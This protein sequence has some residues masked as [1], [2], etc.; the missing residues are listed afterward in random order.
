MKA[1]VKGL[2]TIGYHSYKD[3]N[4]GML[5]KLLSLF[6]LVHINGQELYRTETVT[7]F[8]DLCLFAPAGLIDDRITWEE[9]DEVSAKA[10]FT[11]NGAEISAVLYFNQ[12]GQLVNF[13]SEDRISIAEMKTFPFS[14]PVKNYQN[15]NGYYLPT[16]GEAV[17][18][19][20]NGKF[21]YGKFKVKEILYNQKFE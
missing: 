15:I 8:N 11:T 13:I 5:I 9:I 16:Y 7:F 18:H 4:A 21:V 3:G 1:K 10:T 6:P 17:W 19:Y 12:R 20:P 2:P 14:T